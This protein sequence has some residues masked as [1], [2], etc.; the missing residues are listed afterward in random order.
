LFIALSVGLNSRFE[1]LDRAGRN[2]FVQ[3]LVLVAVGLAL[4][5]MVSVRGKLQMLLTRVVF[6][7]RDREPAVREIRYAG[8]IANGEKEFLDR[9]AEIVARFIEAARFEVHIVDRWEKS[10]LPGEAFITSHS[11]EPR[12]YCLPWAEVLLPA[13]FHKGDGAVIVLGRREGGIRYLSEDLQELGRLAV[14]IVEQVERLRTSEIQRLATQ[15]ELRALQSQINPHFLFNSLNTLYGTIPR[16]APQARQLVLDLADLFRYFLQTDR[17][18]IPLS[19]ELKIV[20]AYV[21]IEKLRLGDRLHVEIDS[22]EEAGRA[23][24][25]VLSVQPLVENAVKHGVATRSGPGTVRLHARTVEAGVL[26]EV[27]D[28]GRGFGSSSAAGGGAGIGLD[29]VRQ[30]LKLCFGEPAALHI[31]SSETGTT[32]SF[33]I[34][35]A[36]AVRGAAQEVTA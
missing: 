31:A 8:T 32:V 1:I 20:R 13:R 27:C 22:S 3:G 14:V 2:P 25:P 9:A 11:S 6:R 23:L 12:D 26:I 21:Q 35:A 5:L 19:D 30:R 4:V 36:H 18:L 15:A 34:P 28:D 17:T 24:I 29:N 7:R 10:E 33:L 16:S